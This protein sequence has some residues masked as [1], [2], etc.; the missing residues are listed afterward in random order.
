MKPAVE[1]QPYHCIDPR[2]NI[3][4]L[5]DEHVKDKAIDHCANDVEGG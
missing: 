1:Y 2:E 5:L 4:P 3:S